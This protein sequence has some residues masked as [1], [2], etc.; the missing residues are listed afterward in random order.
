[1]PNYHFLMIV[2]FSCIGVDEAAPHR[3]GASQSGGTRRCNPLGLPYHDEIRRANLIHP[4][5]ERHIYRHL[6]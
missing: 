3:L 6:D 1:M 2:P 4:D 5:Q